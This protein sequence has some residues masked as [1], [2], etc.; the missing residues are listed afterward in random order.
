MT[1]PITAQPSTQPNNSAPAD[2]VEVLR[3]KTTADFLAAFPR[4]VGFTAPHSVF[5]VFFNGNRTDGTLR[6]DLPPSESAAEIS[7]YVDSL[8]KLTQDMRTR[9]GWESPAVVISSALTFSDARGIPWRKLA[10]SL[11]RRL[12][13]SG[14]RARELCCIAPDGWA[15]YLDPDTPPLG[16]PLSEISASHV[17]SESHVPNLTE[18]SDFSAPSSAAEDVAAALADPQA[19]GTPP[20][21]AALIAELCSPGERDSNVDTATSIGVIR[22][23][24]T[25]YGWVGLFDALAQIAVRRIDAK[26]T[27]DD[28]A[29]RAAHG[30]L[31]RASER[32]VHIVADTPPEM[33]PAVIALCAMAWSLRG[34]Q[35][36]AH[37]QI[38]QALRLDPHHEI[39]LT[40]ER[41]IASEPQYV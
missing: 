8:C 9:Y 23:A 22:T 33:Q 37:T 21:A 12:A 4:L 31:Q 15:S 18:F 14:N 20:T 17:A 30:E 39:A 3:C 38:S 29:A 34:M 13:R 1:T 19:M 24:T 5:I 36:V 10:R 26:V 16:R 25:Y 28:T 32:L 35:S 11:E 41:L 2:P 6:V 27:G 40:A 7:M